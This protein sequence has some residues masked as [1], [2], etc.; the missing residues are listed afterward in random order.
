[1]VIYKY[2]SLSNNNL[3]NLPN[4][5]GNWTNLEYFLLSGNK[6]TSLPKK[7]TNLTILQMFTYNIINQQ[8]T[9]GNVEYQR[10]FNNDCI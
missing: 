9:K 4:S 8:F 6:L 5:F 7:I 1:M 3:T 2:F 10:M